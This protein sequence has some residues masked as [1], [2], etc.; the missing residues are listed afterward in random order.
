MKT[1]RNRKRLKGK[2]IIF[3]SAF[4]S[5]STAA[6]ALPP[7]RKVSGA[8][9]K[10]NERQEAGGVGWDMMCLLF[11]G[12]ATVHHTCLMCRI[13]SRLSSFMLRRDQATVPPGVREHHN[14]S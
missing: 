9:L 1:G 5:S 3:H 2:R 8:K 12:S 14:K 10:I 11:R 4:L 7:E 13:T 6:A